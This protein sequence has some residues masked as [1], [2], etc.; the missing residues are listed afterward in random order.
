ME[1]GGMMLRLRASEQDHR[2][3]Q[4]A[5]LAVVIHVLESALP[6]PLPGVKPGLANV[7]TLAV[8]FIYGLRAAIWVSL[9]RVLAGSL[10][11]GT[12]LSPTFVLS[13]GGAVS[14]LLLMALLSRTGLLLAA[15]GPAD[16][17]LGPVGVAVL[18]GQAHMLGQFALAYV[19]FIPHPALL[20]LLPVLLGMAL[21]FGLL[22]G[23]IG[24]HLLR[25][26]I[27]PDVSALESNR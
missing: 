5:A 18:A 15:P 2:I 22:S 23:Y 27:G 9:L 13:L 3:A 26:L 11:A 6:S 10:L 24:R 17:R 7:I 25:Q 14:S 12:F 19:L 21:V 4:L 1:S 20:G 16:W 8:L